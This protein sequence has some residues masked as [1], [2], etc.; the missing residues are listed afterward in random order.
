MLGFFISLKK[1]LCGHCGDQIILTSFWDMRHL[2]S[3]WWL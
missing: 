1:M 3:S 2:F